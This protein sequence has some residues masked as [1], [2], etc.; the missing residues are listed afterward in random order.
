MKLFAELVE[1]N[2]KNLEGG[3]EKKKDLMSNLKKLESM[4][5]EYSKHKKTS[6]EERLK[7]I[8]SLWK[9]EEDLRKVSRIVTGEIRVIEVENRRFT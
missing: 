5:K 1:S 6:D 9:H 2:K 8:E 3:T 4:M 7:D